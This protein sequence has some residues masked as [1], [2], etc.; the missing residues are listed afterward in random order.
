[1]GSRQKPPLVQRYPL[2]MPL[3]HELAADAKGDLLEL[4]PRMLHLTEQERESGIMGG[5][6]RR[7]KRFAGRFMKSYPDDEAWI[8]FLHD[9]SR[10]Q[11]LSPRASNAAWSYH[12]SF[13][14]G[15]VVF[16]FSHGEPVEA[17][18]YPRSAFYNKRITVTEVEPER[19]DKKYRSLILSMYT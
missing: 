3:F 15:D 1:M 14:G 12:F 8:L 16:D 10:I 9:S 13:R 2:V 11:L 5:C 6:E 7:V 4:A 19:F 18:R 17:R